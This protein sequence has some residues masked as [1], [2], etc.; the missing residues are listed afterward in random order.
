VYCSGKT[1]NSTKEWN[2]LRNTYPTMKQSLAI[3]ERRLSR[4]KLSFVVYY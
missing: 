3:R 4:L 1:G 2:I